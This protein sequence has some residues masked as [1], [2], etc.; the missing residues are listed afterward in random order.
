MWFM[1]YVHYRWF[2]QL[3]FGLCFTTLC[4]IF[5]DDCS[6]EE[7]LL[8]RIKR[9]FFALRYDCVVVGSRAVR[10]RFTADT[11]A[12]KRWINPGIT[13]D[14][15]WFVHRI[16]AIN[17]SFLFSIVRRWSIAQSLSDTMKY[18]W[19]IRL[20]PVCKGS[21]ER[22]FVLSKLIPF[23]MEE[24]TSNQSQTNASGFSSCFV[25]RYI[26]I[27][28][29]SINEVCNGTFRLRLEWSTSLALSTPLELCFCWLF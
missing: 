20:P 11:R 13:I 4:P 7:P 10:L 22:Y 24:S 25:T 5:L 12:V 15:C 21:C 14:G 26:D 9:P 28:K 2:E 8:S 1:W 23:S 27:V 29:Q 19:K 16:V 17:I 18:C 6:S 3:I